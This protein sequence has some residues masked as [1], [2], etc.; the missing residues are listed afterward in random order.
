M[1]EERYPYLNKE[2]EI[3]MEDIR[4]DNWRDV[5]EDANDKK[6]I[7]ALRLEIYVKYQEELIKREF[8]ESVTH[9]KRGNF[10]TF[11]NNH[12][13]EEK[14]LYKAIGLHGFDYKLFDE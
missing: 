7:H 8:L 11:V 4:E 9:P 3:I 14:E 10:W 5:F 12:I 2:E 13:I 1:L 6:K